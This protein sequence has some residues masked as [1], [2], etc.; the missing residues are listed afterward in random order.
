MIINII[1]FLLL[2]G[3]ALSSLPVHGSISIIDDDVIS[4]NLHANKSSV[5]DDLDDLIKKLKVENVKPRIHLHLGEKIIEIINGTDHEQDCFGELVYFFLY[6][7]VY[8][9]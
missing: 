1:A 8:M 6:I 7:H 5:G 3:G 4:I 9:R 2:A